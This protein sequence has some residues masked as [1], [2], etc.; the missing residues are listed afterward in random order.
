[1]RRDWQRH[2]L[3]QDGV[4]EAA[5]DLLSKGFRL[6]LVAAHDDDA[7]FRVVYLFLA[8]RPDRRVELEC[9]VPRND[10]EVRSLAYLSFAAGRFERE[11]ADL[12]GMRLVGHPKAR[13]LVRHAHWPEDWHP[14]RRD[15]SPAPEFGGTGRF[16]FVTVEGPGVYEIPVGPVHA[17][18]IEP[19]HFRF[20]VAGETV[21]RLKARL[22]FVHRGL[23][24]LFEGRTAGGAVDLAERVSGDTSVA[25]AL[26]H[27][28]AVEDALGVELPDEA[29]R[30]RAMLVELERL[31]NHV[32]DL[33][34]L[35]NDVGFALAH[36]H[37]QRVREQLLRLNAAV[38]G[39]RLLRG[40]IRPGAIA[41]QEL[42][43][44]AVLRSVA[45]DVAEIADLT[46]RNTV[47]YDRFAGTAVL[48]PEDA[49]ALGCL[50]YV[51]R[52]SG[53]RT[54]ARVEHAATALP[55]TEIGADAGDVLAR[56][57]VRRDE[58]A[59]STE[60]A[61]HLIESHTGPT[62][63]AVTSTSPRHPRSGI[64]IVEGWRGTVVH[65]VEIDARDRI[66]RSKIVDP[67]WFN[68]PA[69]PVAMADT[70][71]PDFPLA[72]KSFN[73]SYAGNDL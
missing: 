61:C 51:A 72:N 73:Q 28:L 55:V 8:G 5:E 58:F 36:A 3:S 47:V 71:V 15:A 37:T 2:R 7:A 56:Y 31:Y 25:H 69:L 42:P 43:D 39:H 20:S 60:L 17:G 12:Y 27:C 50:G 57:T 19:G 41:L 65:R 30:L 24:K 35:A 45:A 26:A 67:S 59:A 44:V 21:L 48:H 70:I 66:T 16:P 33:G 11:M 14:M 38:T 54:D 49:H 40:A 62:E 18:L 68:W 63:H 1:M 13:R 32:A 46:L 22:W 52:A 29:H 4:A 64:G 6:G 34:A 23:E 53:M 9:L 10:P